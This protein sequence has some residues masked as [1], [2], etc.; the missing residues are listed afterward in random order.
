MKN[1]YILLII[2][3]AALA[4]GCVDSKQTDTD[5]TI[6]PDSTNV[7]TASQTIHP[8]PPPSSLQDNSEL[9]EFGF[10]D[11]LSDIDSLLSDSELDISLSEVNDDLFT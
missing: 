3:V 1:G 5:S 2:L 4:I 8:T 7:D 10:D 11:D 6:E 9:D